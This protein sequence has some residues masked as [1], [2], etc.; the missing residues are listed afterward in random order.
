MQVLTQLIT[1]FSE[2]LPFSA[3]LD[4]LG[5]GIAGELFSAIERILF[6]VGDAPHFQVMDY[7]GGV[8]NA[9]AAYLQTKGLIDQA[10]IL[11]DFREALEWIAALA[12]LFSIA[13][14]VGAIAVFGNYRQGL[15][16]LIG[17]PLF[18]YMIDTKIS[19]NGTELRI[20]DRVVEGAKAD[21]N[22]M[23]TW[24]RAIDGEL[25]N[26]GGTSNAGS[27][28]VSFFFGV[29]DNIVTEAVQSIVKLFI[30]TNAKDDLRFV[31]RERALN[32]V[33]QASPPD[34]GFLRLVG[35]SFYGDCGNIQDD[36]ERSYA[37]GKKVPLQIRPEDD[38]QQSS[39]RR[40]KIDPKKQVDLDTPAKAFLLA[41]KKGSHP[42]FKD[43]PNW[44]SEESHAPMVSCQQIWNWVGGACKSLAEERLTKKSFEGLSQNNI[45]DENWDKVYQDVKNWLS[46]MVQSFNN[47]QTNDQKARDVLAAYI[48]KNTLQ[49]G[50]IDALTTQVFSRTPFNARQYNLVFG[51]LAKAEAHGAYF[52]L[53]YFAHAIPY[54]QGLL[55]YLLSIGFPF[56]AVFL[57]LPGRAPSFFVWCSLWVWVKSWD[58]GFALVMVA[59]DIFWHMMSQRTN[60][61]KENVDWNNPL[62]II[63]TVYNNDPFMTQNT[64][65]ELAGALTVA[66]PLVTAHLCLGATGFYSMFKGSIDQTADRF[67]IAETAR[68][69][70]MV[71]N[72]LEH[73]KRVAGFKYGEA[74][75]NDYNKRI[76]SGEGGKYAP[77][78]LS[79]RKILPFGGMQ[80]LGRGAAYLFG[81]N[82][83]LLGDRGFTDKINSGIDGAIA[84]EGAVQQRLAQAAKGNS[85][86]PEG[87]KQQLGDYR[88][89]HPLRGLGTSDSPVQIQELEHI[90]SSLENAY[91]NVVPGAS[92]EQAT[93][94][95]EGVRSEA[96]KPENAGKYIDTGMTWA[97]LAAEQSEYHQHMQ[98]ALGAVTTRHMDKET[99]AQGGEI[100]KTITLTQQLDM[101]S[102]DPAAST[103]SA[104]M[105]GI[106]TLMDAF[107]DGAATGD[108]GRP[109]VERNPSNI[110]K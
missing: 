42:E 94:W 10:K 25:D 31:A 27:V 110:I 47:G 38:L 106:R 72:Q 102:R 33:L 60:V 87:S 17:P 8:G 18:Y 75:S 28:E 3:T 79:G 41:M 96:A 97:D 12:W 92:Q 14:A 65:W 49:S 35:T 90:Y 81:I 101:L 11:T 99:R 68:S 88:I 86:I 62:S 15:Y 100:A 84:Q 74:R 55:L 34:N 45:S 2:F 29:F 71:G 39:D 32:Y 56:F 89:T 37:Q 73:L 105:L 107:T 103:D 57:V 7:Q 104:K 78:T 9:V 23:L 44:E 70:R 63:S 76:L 64:Y 67:R 93:K 91:L 82:E 1:S 46:S 59:R 83:A 26:Q 77:S 36:L 66:V 19:T 22:Q 40:Q 52:K 30:D 80:S 109:G 95:A 53:K 43:V 50:S 16:L 5:G 54:I 51:P 85:A 4:F 6:S 21:Q 58:I 20:G 69:R 24:I 108:A 61:F 48:L 98:A 13:M